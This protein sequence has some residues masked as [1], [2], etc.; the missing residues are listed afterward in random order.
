[1]MRVA[2]FGFL[3]SVLMFSCSAPSDSSDQKIKDA[4]R[5]QLAQYPASTLQDLYKNFFQDRFGPGH[6]MVDTSAA[7]AYV[8][9][10]LAASDSLPGPYYEPTGS[11]GNFYRVNLSVIRQNLVPFTLYAQAFSESVKNIVPPSQ[12][13]WMGEWTNILRIIRSMNLNL[14]HFEEDEQAITQMLLKGENVVHHS[15]AF[16]AAYDP[17]YRII[18]K[19]IFEQRILPLLKP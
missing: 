8:K 18:S 15:D 6:M 19:E 10:E 16:I 5:A 2:A 11:D 3:I 1:M 13:K 17:H 12:D 14:S 7:Y 9:E 4:V